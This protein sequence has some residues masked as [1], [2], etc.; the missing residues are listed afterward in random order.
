MHG[1][2]TL[3]HRRT[4]PFAMAPIE[5]GKPEVVGFVTMEKPATET[6]AFRVDV[7]KAACAASA[8]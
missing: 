5:G 3:T 7:R 6:G 1:E 2:D 8:S 4:M